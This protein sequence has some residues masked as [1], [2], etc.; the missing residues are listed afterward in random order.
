MHL[1]RVEAEVN[2]ANTASVH[3]LQRLG[4]TR[5]GL[6]RQRWVDKGQA[7]DVAAFGLLRDEYPSA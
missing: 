5:E 3:L 4:F 6:L 2:P 7:Y 1:R